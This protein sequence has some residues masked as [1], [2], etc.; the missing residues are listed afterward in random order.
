MTSQAQNGLAIY[1]EPSL[2]RSGTVGEV[3]FECKS[4]KKRFNDSGN[5]K[6]HERIHT[7]EKPF[8]CKKCKEC[9]SWRSSLIH[10]EKSH[11]CS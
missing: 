4:C 9:F 6:S 10:H 5:L 11:K 3:P 7:G 1:F 2:N 8:S